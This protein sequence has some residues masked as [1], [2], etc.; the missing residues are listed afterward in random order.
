MAQE[1]KFQFNP[2]QEGGNQEPVTQT[3]PEKNNGYAHS[4]QPAPEQTP[5]PAE[6]QEPENGNDPEPQEPE[7]T[8]P[9]PEEGK[10]KTKPAEDPKPEPEQD[11]DDNK[12]LEQLKKKGYKGNSLEELLKD[13]ESKPA[14]KTYDE[15]TQKFLEYQERTGRGLKDYQELNKDYSKMSPVEVAKDR[16]KRESGDADLTP[17][18][19][20]YLLEEELGFDPSDKDLSDQEKAKFKRFYGSH[21]STLKTEQQKYNDP[22][23]GY[24]SPEEKTDSQP[25]GGKKIQL[26]DGTE[27]DEESYLKG[28]K[29]YLDTRDAALQNLKP[30]TFKLTYDGK[31]GKK[32]LDFDLEYT[33]EDLHSMKSITEDVGSILSNYQEESGEFKHADFNRDALW[34]KKDFREKAIGK[35][36]SKARNEVIAE[37]TRNRKNVNFNSPSDFPEPSGK[38]GY[39]EPGQ[40]APA[41]GPSVKYPFSE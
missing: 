7:P 12:L 37:F 24:Q 4:T 26:S 6:P 11:F 22:I 39:T 13:K 29:K 14:P 27:V 33:D 16:I 8:N 28:R 41:S 18:D 36:L 40:K 34:M 30:D 35:L 20:N 9:E 10:D 38:K 17:Q 2:D 32:E 23:E 31:D 15:E 25:D 1:V 21:L 19:L 3:E 5:E